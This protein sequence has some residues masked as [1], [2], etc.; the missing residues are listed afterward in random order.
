MIDCIYIVVME[1]GRNFF[2]G[3]YNIGF[4]NAFWLDFSFVL[5]VMCV[6]VLT[7]TF[8]EDAF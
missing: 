1:I 8:I 5:D 4:L 6:F 7:D 3:K 2:E